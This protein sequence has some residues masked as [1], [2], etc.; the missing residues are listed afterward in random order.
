[1]LRNGDAPR[2]L[3]WGHLLTFFGDGKSAPNA[4]STQAQFAAHLAM[5]DASQIAYFNEQGLFPVTNSALAQLKNDAYVTEWS[6]AA[7]SALRDEPS[8]WPNS[9][10][11]T[12]I[13]GEEVQ[14]ALLGLKA[15]A[16]AI[17]SMAKRMQAKMAELPK[18]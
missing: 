18:T 5:N 15:P 4:Q 3:A 1:V 10:D 12:A 8:F 9:A 13:V 17:E 14:S 16:A 7:R 11:L 2:S 6:A